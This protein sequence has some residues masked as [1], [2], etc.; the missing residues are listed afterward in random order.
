M[1]IKKL[2]EE[3]QNIKNRIGNITKEKRKISALIL[4]AIILISFWYCSPISKFEFKIRTFKTISDTRIVRTG[5]DIQFNWEVQGEPYQAMIIFG[6]GNIKLIDSPSQTNGI[7]SGNVIHS[8]ALQGK[9]QPTLRIWD[10][11]GDAFT[12][13]LELEVRNDPPLFD[14]LVNGLITEQPEHLR[15]SDPDEE[16]EVFEDEEVAIDIENKE[17]MLDNLTFIFDFGTSKKTSKANSTIYSWEKE[18]VYPLIITAIGSQ[19]ELEQQTRYINVKNKAPIANFSLDYEYREDHIVMVKVNASMSKDTKSDYNSLRYYWDWDDG[20]SDWGK[21]AHHSFP[22]AGTYNIT[23]CVRD[24]D[25]FYDI[26]SK[27][28]LINNTIPTV[29]VFGPS[30]NTTLYE[31]QVITFNAQGKDDSPNIVRLHYYWNFNSSLFN[32]DDLKNY[33]LGGLINDHVFY[34]DFHGFVTSAIIDPQGAYDLDSLNVDILNVDPDLSIY[35]ANIIGNVTFGLYRSNLNSDLNFTFKL[36]NEKDKTYERMIN[37]ANETSSYIYSE[38][39][40]LNFDILD[41]WIITVNSS[42][43]IPENEEYQTLLIFE[44]LD[45]QKLILTSDMLSFGEWGYFEDNL[46]NYFYD[47]KNYT[48]KYPI[49]INIELFDPSIDNIYCSIN[50]IEKK[51]LEISTTSEI[52]TIDELY[53]GD[54]HYEFQFYQKNGKNFV[55]I[56]ASR[57]ID[58]TYY[59]NNSFPV[60]LEFSAVILPLINVNE[61]LKDKLN[62]TNLVV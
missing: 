3:K 38:K 40:Q 24:D 32:L 18:G 58:S 27:I 39:A 43:Q 29:E 60:K 37:F 42:Q 53:I 28:F 9:Y 13:S 6:D 61:L 25:G 4:T 11:W 52:P 36:S 55:N 12:K 48:F 19:G 20:T 21:Y 62:L 30:T 17:L 34:D 5:E 54:I 51:L 45:G 47:R 46:T 49:S 14:V 1:N 56:T 22:D 44:F 26:C 35:S 23:L 15:L 2:N 59:D 10:Y 41:N 31:G 50:H 7:C 8:Y 33:E 57:L 16:I